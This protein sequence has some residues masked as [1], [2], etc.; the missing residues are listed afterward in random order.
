[1][2]AKIVPSISRRNKSFLS[3]IERL[4]QND[5]L[6]RTLEFYVIYV[7]KCGRRMGNLEAKQEQKHQG[8]LPMLIE[9]TSKIIDVT[10]TIRERIQSRFEKLE[11]LQV[12]LITPHVI[13]AKEGQQFIIEATA[14][15]PNGKLFAEAEHE[16]LYAAVTLLGQK[17]ERQLLR[18]TSRPASHRND[19]IGKEL[20]RNSEQTSAA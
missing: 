12:P 20:I 2:G 6:F 18:H 11:R 1:M 13:I 9:I 15:V 7:T 3:V 16:D 4:S 17:L 19:R 14:G 5:S 10:P 8:G